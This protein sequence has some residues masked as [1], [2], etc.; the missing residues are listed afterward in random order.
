MLNTSCKPRSHLHDPTDNCRYQAATA[1]SF[2]LPEDLALQ[3]VT[4][5]PAKSLGMDHRIGYVRAGYDADIVVFDSHPLSIGATALQVYIDGRATLDEEKVKESLSKVLPERAQNQPKPKMRPV[6]DPSVREET[7]RNVAEGKTVITGITKS[8]LQHDMAIS[9]PG[10]LTLVLDKGKL[11]CLDTPENCITHSSG[12]FPIHLQNGHVLPGLTAAVT[13]AGMIEIDMEDATGDGV[14]SSKLDPLDPESVVYAKYG[15]RLDSRAFERAMIGGV[16]RVVSVPLSNGFLGGVSVG[17][18]TSGRKTIV[19]G[20]VFMDE[21][22]LHF[23][24][25]Q[26]SK[27]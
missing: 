26:E 21:V 10:N 25:G 3:S 17:V 1:H 5:V 23:T 8:Y 19:D 11:I 13:P 16:T 6:L 15:V 2:H 9:S 7:C 14:V 20:G 12:G 27:G 18:E 4:S 22:A 24:L